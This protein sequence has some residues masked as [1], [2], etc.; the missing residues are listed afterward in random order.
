MQEPPGGP[1]DFTPPKLVSV[2]PDSGSIHPGWHDAVRFTFDEVVTEP[3]DQAFPKLILV[4]PRP[5]A[6]NLGW[7]RT[8]LSVEP[9]GGWK[10]NITYRVELLPGVTDLRNNRVTQRHVVVFSTGGDIPTGSIRA[11][12]VDWAGG[13]LVTGAGLVE[14]IAL[15]DSLTYLGVTDSTGDALIDHLAAGRYLVVGTIDQNGN[16]RRDP[17]E[18]FDSV[19]LTLDSTATRQ[20]WTFDHDTTGPRLRTATL[21]DSVTARIEFNQMLAL[22]PP[23]SSAVHVLALPDST[24]V[25]LTAVLTPAAYDTLTRA[26][27]RDKARADSIKRASQ[28][29]TARRAGR[30]DTTRAADTT[31][32]I[33]S[34]ALPT[35]AVAGAG[36]GARAGGA[37]A[38]P[39]VDTARQNAILR[40]RPKLADVWVLRFAAPIPVDA[41]YLVRASASNLIGA[42]Q[43]S[44]VVLVGPKPPA[45]DSTKGRGAGRGGSGK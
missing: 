28:P 6:L 20:L 30:Q 1:P 36:R 24:P 18:A 37:N 12:L 9:D 7:H 17:R 15:P 22:A 10:P 41:R 43:S 23:D 21:T 44:Q 33:Q 5:K 27:Q 45:T 13:R 4:S 19:T 34:R 40:L 42:T 8:A 38:P 2:T 3:Q 14:A 32:R 31:V 16:Q 11:T 29:D 26:E 39:P 35:Q 25:A